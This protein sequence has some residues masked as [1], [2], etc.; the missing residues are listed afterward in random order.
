MLPTSLKDGLDALDG[1]ALFREAFG[2][3]FINYYLGLKHAELNR[4]YAYV[5]DNGDQDAENDIS[6]WEQNEYFDFF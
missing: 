4:F 3:T 6:H 2:N 1:S 5:E